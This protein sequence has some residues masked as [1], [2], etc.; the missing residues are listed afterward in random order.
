MLLAVNWDYKKDERMKETQIFDPSDFQNFKQ[1]ILHETSYDPLQNHVL[2]E[3]LIGSN[4]LNVLIDKLHEYAPQK[5]E[6][7]LVMDRTQMWRSG[8]SLKPLV[9]AMLEKASYEVN[10]LFLEGDKHGIVHAD[11]EQVDRVKRNFRPDRILIGLGSGVIADI[12]KYAAF[13]FEQENPGIEKPMLIM[14][15]TANSVPAF[16]SSLS[17][18]SKDGVKRTRKSRLPNLIL[19]DV[20]VLL[21]S[22]HEMTLGGIGDLCAAFI[23]SVEWYIGRY[24][25]AVDDNLAAQLLLDYAK[26]R[27][28][29]RA[30]DLGEHKPSG[31]IELA[32][33]LSLGA[34][35]MTFVQ[36]STPMSGYEHGV[37]H[38]LDMSAN[39]FGRPVASHGSQV[40]IAGVIVLVAI[41]DFLDNFDPCQVDINKC[42]PSFSDMEKRVLDG[43]ALFDN[44]GA[45]GQECWNDYKKKLTI[46][47]NNRDT[48]QKMLNDWEEVKA[49]LKM[50]TVPTD[51]YISMLQ[52]A[53]H[54]LQ[55]PEIGVPEEQAKWA[56]AHAF[57]LRKR[58][59]T[60]DLMVFTDYIT[61][62]WVDRIFERSAD[63]ILQTRN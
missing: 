28:I 63:L 9:V 35:A 52:S 37:A 16:A 34:L 23:S 49:T 13:L 22:P 56:F 6:V 29:A 25:G 24:F 43:F 38:L 14:I 2:Q 50:L 10:T 45:M 17:I 46:W 40:A 15:P 18:I 31:A 55:F 36:D 57:M 5:S 39:Y 26:N 41:H 33:I 3:I 53:G 42:F 4:E 8:S 11:F 62:E 48:F 1:A 32:K 19:T 21:D 60:T 54:P 51:A 20:E 7:L 58:L 44:S 61:P 47:H 27:M 59:S 30:D 12:C